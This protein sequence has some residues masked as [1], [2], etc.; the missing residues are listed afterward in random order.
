[1]STS[2]NSPTSEVCEERESPS[3]K[4]NASSSTNKNRRLYQCRMTSKQVIMLVETR[5]RV[6]SPGTVKEENHT[7]EITF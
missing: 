4:S 6:R 1:M 3:R 5:K 2:A 7:R